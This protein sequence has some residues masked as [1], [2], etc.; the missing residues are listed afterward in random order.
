MEEQDWFEQTS[1]SLGYRSM[2]VLCRGEK[3][4]QG[5]VTALLA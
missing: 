4:L 1:K 2:D 5:C 3:G